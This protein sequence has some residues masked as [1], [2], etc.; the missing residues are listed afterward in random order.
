MY[1][2]GKLERQPVRD[3]GDELESFVKNVGC[4]PIL[5]VDNLVQSLHEDAQPHLSALLAER[6]PRGG[7][8]SDLAEDLI[9]WHAAMRAFNIQHAGQSVPRFLQD[10]QLHSMELPP[11]PHSVT[12][13]T[14]HGAKG[15]E[16]RHVYLI[17]LADEVLPTFQSL[18]NGPRSSQVEEERRNCFVAITRAQDQL[19]LSWAEHYSGYRKQ[20]SRF[21]HEMGLLRG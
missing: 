5:E 6:V 19:T 16:F 3:L 17:G 8:E 10:L 12:V 18:Q 13:A 9:G 4:D 11:E 2:A 14:I 15:R 20:P 1:E 7:L 21:L